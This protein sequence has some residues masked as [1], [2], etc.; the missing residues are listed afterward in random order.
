MNFCIYK[1]Y[2]TNATIAAFNISLYQNNRKKNLEYEN[3][4]EAYTTNIDKFSQIYDNLFPI[5]KIYLKL[6]D[7]KSPWIT[8]EIKR[9]SKRKQ[10]LRSVSNNSR[11]NF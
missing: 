2:V 11:T 1:S 5:K 7:L 3:I 9:T 6:K 10:R 8:Q 4:N